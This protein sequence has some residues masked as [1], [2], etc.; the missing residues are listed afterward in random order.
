MLTLYTPDGAIPLRVSDYY[1][2][3]LASGL[4][5][6]CF[7]ISIWDDAFQ[8]IQEESSIREESD[9]ITACNY[10]VKAIDSGKNTANIKAQIDLD[11]WKESLTVAYNSGSN[12]VGGIVRAVAPTGWTVADYSGLTYLRT[13]HLTGITPLGV[14]EQCR[15]T[16]SGVTFRFNNVQKIVEIINMKT[17]TNLGAFVTRDLNLKKTEYKGKSTGFATRLYAYGKD[18]LSIASVNSGLPYVDNNT[19]SNRIVCAYWKDERYTV[20]ENLKAA[21]Q[22]RLAE[23]AV[24]SRSFECDVVDLAKTNPEKYSELDFVMFSV[25]SLID[26]TRSEQKIDHIVVERWIYPNAPQNNKVILS[27]VAPRIQSQVTQIINSMND[28]NSIYQQQQTSKQQS[29]IENATDKITGAKGGNMRAIYDDDGNWTELVIMDT[30]D[31]LTASKLWRFNIGGLGYS[32]NGYNGPYTTAITMDGAIVADFI[33]T[34]TLD[35]SKITVTNLDAGSITTGTLDASNITV[36]NLNAQSITTGY[37]NIARIQDGSITG[38]ENGKIAQRTIIGGSSGNIAEL[39]IK[40]YNLDNSSVTY[41]KAAFQATLD[42][43][44]IN[45]SDIRALQN[46][47]F[48]SLS[49][50]FIGTQ[51]MYISGKILS[52]ST[53]SIGGTNRNIVTWSN[54]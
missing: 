36:T 7:T 20:A 4:N 15:S 39:G 32:P 12:S 45:T 46:G 24:P 3:E 37:L 22:E 27:T 9:G 5:E 40:T 23:L 54:P 19:Y 28:I 8:L 49:A 53:I 50:N 10:L 11:E 2:K 34:G 6:L 21:A 13:L 47:E 1:I 14:L 35:A 29:A 25:V 18:D 31:I 42:Q 51:Y 52:L 48:D 16:F 33:T 38:G 43:V 26:Q 17:G 30:E 44:G 41:P